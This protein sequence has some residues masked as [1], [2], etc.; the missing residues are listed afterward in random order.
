MTQ[1]AWYWACRFALYMTITFEWWIVVKTDFVE[2]VSLLLLYSLSVLCR[3]HQNGEL[4]L[5]DFGLARAFG[6]PVRCYSAEVKR[7]GFRCSGGF[8]SFPVLHFMLIVFRWWR[9]GTGLQMC[10]LVLSYTLPLLT[11]GLQGVYLQVGMASFK[12]MIFSCSIWI[13]FSV[14][15]SV[16]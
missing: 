9:C 14:F 11:C 16:F 7:H 3:C 6:I 2:L 10:C 5:A 15:F 8:Q 1:S 13:Y 4:K 12:I